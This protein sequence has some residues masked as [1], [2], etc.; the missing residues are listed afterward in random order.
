[1]KDGRASYLVAFSVFLVLDGLGLSLLLEFLTE[2]L[3]PR[4]LLLL[5][6]GSD[7]VRGLGE[8]RVLTMPGGVSARIQTRL[9]KVATDVL[10]A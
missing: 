9:D 5:V 4:L 2:F 1:M 7:L 3:E 8:V 10:V 6:Q